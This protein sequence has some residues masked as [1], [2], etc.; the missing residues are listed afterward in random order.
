MSLG[1]DF[2]S[3]PT[4][5]DWEYMLV[6][7]VA[8]RIRTTE[9][10][11]LESVLAIHLLE[12]KTR[13]GTSARNWRAF[14]TTSLRNKASNWIRDRQLLEGRLVSLEPKGTEDSREVG[15]DERSP[16]ADGDATVTLAVHLARAELGHHLTA[17]WDVLVEANGNQ[18]EAARRLR[19]HRNTIRLWLRKIRNTLN[20][21]GLN[22]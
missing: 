11:D 18:V 5:E 21:H 13:F 7:S 19:V 22:P 8:A 12:I 20:R 3:S 17:V 1:H 16:R 14:A 10:E 2:D 4:L 6:R 9:R 15:A